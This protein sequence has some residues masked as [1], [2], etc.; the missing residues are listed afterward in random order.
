MLYHMT[1]WKVILGPGLRVKVFEPGD[2]R[3]KSRPGT[4]KRLV[5]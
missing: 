1:D 4:H 3:A 2:G 5:H